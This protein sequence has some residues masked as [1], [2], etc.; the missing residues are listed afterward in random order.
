MKEKLLVILARASRILTAQFTVLTNDWSMSMR[1]ARYFPLISSWTLHERVIFSFPVHMLVKHQST[2]TLLHENDPFG[3]IIENFADLFNLSVDT[4]T[5][6]TGITD[7][8]K[9]DVGTTL[10]KIALYF[11][12]QNCTSC[13]QTNKWRN[14]AFCHLFLKSWYIDQRHSF[15]PNAA[16]NHCIFVFW[17]QNGPYDVR[18]HKLVLLLLKIN[19]REC[20]PKAIHFLALLLPWGTVIILYTLVPLKNCNILV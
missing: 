16:K 8:I 2:R 17:A 4:K 6:K 18:P 10:L 9:K 15:C 7:E 13:N 20:S 3:N 11:R 5:S 14:Q 1:K 19:Y 12:S